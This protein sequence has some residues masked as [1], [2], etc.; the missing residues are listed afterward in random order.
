ML[1]ELRYQEKYEHVFE[2][3]EGVIKFM[4]C[5]KNMRAPLIGVS[6]HVSVNMLIVCQSRIVRDKG[7][8]SNGLLQRLEEVS[9]LIQYANRLDR[10][11]GSSLP[12]GGRDTESPSPN[13]SDLRVIGSHLGSKPNLTH[14]PLQG[15]VGQARKILGNEVT[16]LLRALQK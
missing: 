8:S 6:S 13:Y 2:M 14:I 1:G 11:P 16:P 4:C 9:C 5:Y 15:P 3:I 10:M 7:G 12:V